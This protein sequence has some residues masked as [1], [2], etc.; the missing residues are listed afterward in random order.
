MPKAI[1]PHQKLP[2]KAALER[3][4]M[5][6]ASYAQLAEKYGVRR[7]TVYNTMALRA[8]KAGTPWPLKQGRPGWE[9]KKAETRG[10]TIDS[11]TA[12]MIRAE[13]QEMRHQPWRILLAQVALESGV[14]YGTVM[15]I[16]SGHRKR[17]TRRVAEAIMAVIERHERQY[18][19][20][21][22]A[23]RAVRIR[24]ERWA[25]EKAAGTRPLSQRDLR[26]TG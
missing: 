23:L 11:I 8:R 20:K 6:G 24:D 18:N 5:A 9:R 7:K 4:Y 1:H 16:S 3:E 14:S 19:M 25:A 17:V 10:R 13:L 22:Q 26:R 2:E 15:Q 12:S 21:A